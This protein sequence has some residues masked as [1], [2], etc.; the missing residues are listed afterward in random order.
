MK[1]HLL[2]N[3][4]TRKPSAGLAAGVSDRSSGTPV[5]TIPRTSSGLVAASR[6]ATRPPN[7]CPTRTGRSSPN[8]RRRRGTRAPTRRTPTCSSRCPAPAWH[9]TPEGRGPAR[10]TPEGGVPVRAGAAPAVQRDDPGRALAVPLGERAPAQQRRQ[11]NRE[12]SA[13]GSASRAPP[14]RVTAARHRRRHRGT[15]PHEPDQSAQ[16]TDHDGVDVRRRRRLEYGRYANPTW[17]AFEEALG[18]LEDGRCLAFASGLA[19]V[20]TVLDLVGRGAKVVAPRHAYLGTSPS[21]ADLERVAGSGRGSSTSPTPTVVGALRRRGPGLAG[22]ADQPGP[23]GRRLPG[24]HRGRPRRRR[25]VVVDNTFATP[26][27]AAA[28]RARRRPG[29]ALG[30]EVPRRPQRP[31]DGGDRHPRR[32]AARRA[33]ESPRLVGPSRERSRPGSRCADCAPCTLRLERA[34]A[35]AQELA[36]R[37]PTTRPWTRCAT[38]ASARSSRSSLADGRPADLLARA[39]RLWV[40]AT[41]LGGVEST[42]ERRRRWK[43]EPATIPEAWCGSRSA[44][45]TSTTSGTTSTSARPAPPLTDR[46]AP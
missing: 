18:A 23:R 45:R 16:H 29:P 38:P 46:P 20:A 42:F 2:R 21:S 22:V 32:R 4:S 11:H 31:G 5:R 17:T 40:H 41:S 7:E 27:A 1:C 12:T 43:P 8:R 33:Q 19:A 37:L 39:T 35:N 44:S 26:A 14:E 24:D 13:H 30:D 25:L 28:A 9:R 10:R 36:R 6:T 3:R 15:A 34:Q